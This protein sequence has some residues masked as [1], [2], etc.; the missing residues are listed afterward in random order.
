MATATIV[1]VTSEASRFP[2]APKIER[3]VLWQYV[4][5]AQEETSGGWHE[6]LSGGEPVVLFAGQ[7][8]SDKNPLLLVEA[9]NKL[10]FSINLVFAGEDKGAASEILAANLDGRHRRLVEPRYLDLAELVSLI[11]LSDV[12]VCPYRVASQSGIVALANQLGRSVIVSS[13]GGLG[14]QSPLTFELGADQSEQLAVRLKA[15][16]ASG[17][18]SDR[19][20]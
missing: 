9:V 8:R 15:V 3:R 19:R 7:L 10:D 4:P 18:D 11:K 1:Y 17:I 6:K 16:L 20:P 2:E 14:E 5:T 12:V 13:A